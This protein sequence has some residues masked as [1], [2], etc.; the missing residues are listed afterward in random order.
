MRLCA[1]LAVQAAQSRENP[2]VGDWSCFDLDTV[3]TLLTH[4]L[5]NGCSMGW[6]W[7]RTEAV[8]VSVCLCVCFGDDSTVEELSPKR[9]LPVMS[10]FPGTTIFVFLSIRCAWLLR[11][12]VPA[13][14]DSGGEN[15]H[16]LGT[17]RRTRTQIASF[18]SVDAFS[19]YAFSWASVS[20]TTLR[21]AGSPQKHTHTSTRAST[22]GSFGTLT[23][24]CA[25]HSES[26]ARESSSLT[27]SCTAPSSL[28][29]LS[30]H[31]R[32]WWSPPYP[33]SA[34][35]CQMPILASLLFITTVCVWPGQPTSPPSAG[36]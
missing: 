32:H 24:A 25:Q 9:L 17:N 36:Q 31:L 4:A 19:V 2:R 14:F 22:A 26:D 33:F 11:Q 21:Q 3:I 8:C 7:S 13:L 34:N 18:S 20:A 15:S 6:R 16:R 1:R 12:R 29:F 27:S 28:A 5:G 30:S 10:F 23:L 35:H